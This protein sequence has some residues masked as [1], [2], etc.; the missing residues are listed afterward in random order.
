[1]TTINRSDLI[2]RHFEG[3]IDYKSSYQNM[4]TLTE[5]RQEST[6]DELWLLQHQDV[7]TQGRA[8]RVEHLIHATTL[9]IVQSDRGGQVTWHGQGQLIA[10]LLYD[11]NRLKWNVR[12]LVTHTENALIELLSLYE[13]EAYAKKD[14]PGVYVNDA[15]IGSLGFKIRQGR[16]YHGLA[17]NINCD[18]SGFTY[19]NP[20]GY[21]G[22]RMTR[23]VDELRIQHP[24]KSIPTF[25]QVTEQL[26][27]ILTRQHQDRSGTE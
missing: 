5:S 1:M 4:K 3:L 9:P 25:E 24:V 21:S 22:L 19:I 23:L 12:Q 10:Y 20:C 17:L 14:A 13:I 7:L 18:L 11:L 8:G 16:S 27:K 2:I 15:K 26:S 6:L